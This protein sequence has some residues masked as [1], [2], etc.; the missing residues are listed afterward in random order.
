MWIVQRVHVQAHIVAGFSPEAIVVDGA[1]K[2]NGM[3]S[4]ADVV[5]PEDAERIR[6]YV[7]S[8]GTEDREAALAEAQATATET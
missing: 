5:S 2:V 7:I 4:F 8:R 1:L 6:Q 3:A